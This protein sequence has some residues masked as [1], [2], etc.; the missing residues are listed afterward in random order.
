MNFLSTQ[1]TAVKHKHILH[2]INYHNTLLEQKSCDVILIIW[3]SY[4]EC[5]GQHKPTI[6]TTASLIHN[7]QEEEEIIRE[8]QQINRECLLTPTT[9]NI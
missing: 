9:F 8:I 2:E 1:V 5:L 4:E 6:N 7:A 3:G